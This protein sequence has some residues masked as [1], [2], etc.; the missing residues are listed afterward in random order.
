MAHVV[1]TGGAGFLGQYLVRQLA[2]R[3]NIVTV[4][5]HQPPRIEVVDLDRWCRYVR[6]DV[7]ITRPETLAG[8]F[9]GADVVYHLAGLVS[10]WL[11]DRARLMAV[12]AAGTG[13]VAAEAIRAGVGR[14]VHLSSVAAVG[15]G[16]RADRPVDERLRFP[17]RTVRHKPYMVS[18]HL[19]ERQIRIAT[20]RGLNAVIVNPGLMW[21]PGDLTNSAELNRRIAAGRLSWCPP[22]GTNIV[23]VRDVAE[24]LPTLMTRGETGERYILGGYNVRFIE[25]YR[26]VAA[27]VARPC[28][29]RMLPPHVRP[30]L[31]A[32]V[33]LV[34]A[35]SRRPP[36]LTSDH[37]DSAFRYRYFSSTKAMQQLGWKPQRALEQTVVDTVA[38]L[39]D[40]QLLA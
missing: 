29:F 24:F 11:K 17:W 33:R 19:A 12:N 14:L 15:Y 32:L 1:V 40:H 3:G 5:D 28:R 30:V 36:P 39:R 21:G 16:S 9:D 26:L 31:Y 25:L 2:E 8:R 37:I 23:D 34:E 22:G 4:L 35:V 38:W 6:F 27:A 10:F 7:D 13:N 20:R 18:K